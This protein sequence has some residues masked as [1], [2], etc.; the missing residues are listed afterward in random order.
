MQYFADPEGGEGADGGNA[1]ADV[2]PDD[3][4]KEPTFDEVLKN[5]AYQSEFDKR[6]NKALE[7]AHEKWEADAKA[8]ADEAAKLAKK[9]I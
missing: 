6:V 1:S 5:K 3:G 9:L 2:K 7:T 8:Q 4:K